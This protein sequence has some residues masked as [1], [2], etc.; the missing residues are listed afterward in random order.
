MPAPRDVQ[1]GLH[2]V[3]CKQVEMN[4]LLTP[5]EHVTAWLFRVAGNRTTGLFRR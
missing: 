1:D 2:D 5:I 3:F 4:R